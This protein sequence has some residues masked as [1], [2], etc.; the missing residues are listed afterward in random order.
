MGPLPIV[1]TFCRQLGI[2]ALVDKHVA[3]PENISSGEVV[4]AMIMDTLTGR[5]PLYKVSESFQHQ[6][7]ELLFGR[8]IELDHFNDNNLG[9]VLD[10]IHATGSSQLFSKISWQAC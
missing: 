3:S 6:D 4:V 7:I 5:S 10:N 8:E 9:K 2:P 1:A